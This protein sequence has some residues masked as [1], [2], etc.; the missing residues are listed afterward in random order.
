M[1]S[2]KIW[3]KGLRHHNSRGK[4]KVCPITNDVEALVGDETEKWRELM[5]S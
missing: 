1:D 5:S 4:H 3:R 2:L